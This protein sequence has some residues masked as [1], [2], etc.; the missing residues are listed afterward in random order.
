MRSQIHLVV[1]HV[2]LI[3]LELLSGLRNCITHSVSF[4]EVPNISF[5]T[6][7]TPQQGIQEWS[8]SPVVVVR[9][10]WFDVD[11]PRK[12]F[13]SLEAVCRDARGRVRKQGS[14]HVYHGGYTKNPKKKLLVQS[15]EAE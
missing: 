1:A 3:L 5:N 13:G 11:I 14:E 7:N 15:Y 6:D 10:D 4:I 12:R 9:V 2:D 8:L